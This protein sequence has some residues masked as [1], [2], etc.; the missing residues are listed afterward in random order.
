MAVYV[1]E[2]MHYDAPPNDDWPYLTSCHMFADSLKELIDFAKELGL[3]E[4]W[5][6][7][8]PKCNL[9]HFDLTKTKRTLALR[10][11]AIPIKITLAWMHMMKE[12][13]K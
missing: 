13:Y 11:G 5:I 1:D 7:L 10:K 8:P 12:K 9:P 4:E 3:R 6:Q 2:V